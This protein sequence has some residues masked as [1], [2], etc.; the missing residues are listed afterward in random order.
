MTIVKGA[1]QQ[2]IWGYEG[3]DDD[4]RLAGKRAERHVPAL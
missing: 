1:C 4:E 2:G 3:L